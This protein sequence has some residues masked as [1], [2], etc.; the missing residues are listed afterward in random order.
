MENV[1][2]LIVKMY[3]HILDYSLTGIRIRKGTSNGEMGGIILSP[4]LFNISMGD[5]SKKKNSMDDLSKKN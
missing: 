3:Q 5:L 1:L 4:S 2:Q